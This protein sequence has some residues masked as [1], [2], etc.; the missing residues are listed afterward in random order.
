MIELP[1]WTKNNA[2]KH[3]SEE[4]VGSHGLIW[5]CV[6]R[7]RKYQLD[8]EQYCS[9]AIV[10]EQGSGPVKRTGNWLFGTPSFLGFH[11]PP[12]KIGET[13]AHWLIRIGANGQQPKFVTPEE[14]VTDRWP[15]RGMLYDPNL[16]ALQLK[17]HI[18]NSSTSLS[19]GKQFPVLFEKRP[20]GRIETEPE[21]INTLEV[22][23]VPL[24]NQDDPDEN[25][26][27]FSGK[28]AVFVFDAT[29]NISDIQKVLKLELKRVKE[30]ASLSTY[31]DS[32]NTLTNMKNVLRA[33]DAH[34]QAP[35]TSFHERGKIIV[36][37]DGEAQSSRYAAL[38]G[39]AKSLIGEL[40]CLSRIK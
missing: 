28:N 35:D 20:A 19:K 34:K 24:G 22:D 15:M 5:E 4:K 1:D 40:V 16:N 39:R 31:S 37:T 12:M 3:I 29:Q 26:E 38:L 18:E 7:N 33:W 32:G 21:R 25:L 13:H 30:I 10:D 17:E 6:R 8:Y 11:R 36:G 14:L 27:F 2:Y 9:G 23:T